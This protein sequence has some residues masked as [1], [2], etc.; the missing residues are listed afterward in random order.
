MWSYL[1]SPSLLPL[2]LKAPLSLSTSGVSL[3]LTSR[4]LMWEE[5]CLEK[6]LVERDS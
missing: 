2:I 4:V 3:I 1:D 6:R 5:G